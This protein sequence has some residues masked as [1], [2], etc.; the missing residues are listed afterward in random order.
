MTYVVP[1]VTN[2]MY[3]RIRGTNLGYN[4]VKKDNTGTKIV[5]GTDAMGSPLINTPGTNNADMA[6]DDLWFYS[7]PIFVA[8]N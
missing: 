7:N 1:N 4:V 3:F 2:D 5:Y 8:V 6:W